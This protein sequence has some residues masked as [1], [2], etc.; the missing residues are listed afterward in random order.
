MKY[1]LIVLLG[2]LA[3]LQYKLWVEKQG[4]AQIVRLKEERAQLIDQNIN[5][6]KQNKILQTRIDSYK[7]GTQGFEAR[8]REDLG[9]TKK[10]EV[11]YQVVPHFFAFYP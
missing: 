6:E 7:R 2:L 9:M 8:A 5:L 1:I 3:F 10:D 4:V 11:F